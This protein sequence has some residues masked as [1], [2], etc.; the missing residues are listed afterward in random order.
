MEMPPGE[1]NPDDIASMTVLKGPAAAALY[2]SR[3][4]N[5]AILITTKNGKGKKGLGVTINSNTTFD[6]P[7]VLPQWQDKYGQ[8]NN[9]QFEFVNGAG[10]GIADGVDES[11]GPEMDTGLLIPQFDSP[12]SVPGFRGGDLNAPAGSTITPTPWVSQP[13]NINDFFPN[14]CDAFK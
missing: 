8:G 12:R 14:R 7:L 13:D 5:G 4:A 10:A 11:W 6:N 9:G 1:I 2:G 3:A